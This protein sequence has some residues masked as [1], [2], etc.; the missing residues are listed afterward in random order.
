MIKDVNEARGQKSEFFWVF[1]TDIDYSELR[2]LQAAI[3]KSSIYSSFVGHV[4]G[5]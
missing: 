5:C 1:P 3:E 2:Q 4:I